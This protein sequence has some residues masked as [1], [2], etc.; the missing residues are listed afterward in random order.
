[1]SAEGIVDH[2]VAAISK[3]QLDGIIAVHGLIL[4]LEYGA[5]TRFHECARDVLALLG[6]NS[7]HSNLSTQ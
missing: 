6:V 1:M 3:P 7:G 4:D 2:C 5:G